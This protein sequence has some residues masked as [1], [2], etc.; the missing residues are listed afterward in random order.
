MGDLSKI[1]VR[2]VHSE[3]FIPKGGRKNDLRKL[4]SRD[5]I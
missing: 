3:H 5:E 2:Q 1:V 4:R